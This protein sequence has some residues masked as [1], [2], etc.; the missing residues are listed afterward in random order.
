MPV[1]DQELGSQVKSEDIDFQGWG[2]NRDCFRP[3]YAGTIGVLFCLAT[4]AYLWAWN[5]YPFYFIWDMDLATVL[6]LIVIKSGL[7]PDHVN[8]PGFGMYLLLKLCTLPADLAGLL[9]AASLTTLAKALDPLAC[10]AE[11][12]DFVRLLSPVICLAT[13]YFLGAALVSFLDASAPLALGVWAV[14]L[15]QSSFFYH[16]TMNRSEM[17]AI[18]FWSLALWALACSR[19]CRQGLPF[20]A[21]TLAAGVCLGLAFLTKL[22]AAIYVMFAPVLFV[23]LSRVQGEKILSSLA[24]AASG[25]RWGYLVLSLVNGVFFSGTLLLSRFVEPPEGVWSFTDK[26]ALTTYG[27]FFLAFYAACP[28]G[29]LA[30]R[31]RFPGATGC[32]RWLTLLGT[33][34]TGCGLLHFAVLPQA[35]LGWRYLLV[36]LKMAYFRAALYGPRPLSEYAGESLALLRY[37]PATIV[38]HACALG[39]LLLWGK[40][41]R[42]ARMLAPAVSLAAL[43]CA[44]LSSRPILRDFL[45]WEILLN[46]LT[47]AYVLLLW[48]GGSRPC[49]VVAVAVLLILG[50]GNVRLDTQVLARLDARYSQYGW[51]P[52]PW[53]R[54]VFFGAQQRYKELIQQR[55]GY[56]D[57]TAKTAT[58][59]E[60]RHAV[61][62]AAIRRLATFVF[63]NRKVDLRQVGI[64]APGFPAFVNDLSLRLTTVP[65]SLQG[66]VLVDAEAAP[67]ASGFLPVPPEGQITAEWP[68]SD[69]VAG[70]DALA[71]LPRSDLAVWMFEPAG[72]TPTGPE[73]ELSDGR[74]TLRLVGRRIEKFAWISRLK[75]DSH[76]VFILASPYIP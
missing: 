17:Y 46:V 71:V 40:R 76:R 37:S 35:A 74:R 32:L 28:I 18:L 24:A 48:Q 69:Y 39:A 41:V 5:R 22:Q 43:A 70:S 3:A 47:L 16:S 9:S 23:F 10:V 7:H 30:A 49:R 15:S 73:L 14:L 75:A 53:L 13:A 26:Y 55:Y 62:H 51:Q 2:M 65:A 56:T 67:E 27:L 60:L 38:A 61:R 44:V 50:L 63:P 45:W 29:L 1:V 21:W 36:D 64:A 12:T 57:E 8:H 52:Q 6:D 66:S 72:D 58:G 59:P 33:G 54:F 68:L 4:G 11:V 42:A 31:R 25:P 34:F 19:R 20:V